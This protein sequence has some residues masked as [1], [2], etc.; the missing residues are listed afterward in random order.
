[1]FGIP[2]PY[3]LGSVAVY[4]AL[5]LLLGFTYG[6]T[7]GHSAKALAAIQRD[8]D[9]ANAKIN[10]QKPKDEAAVEAKQ[11]AVDEALDQAGTVLDKMHCAATKEAA[12]I[13]NRIR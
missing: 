1:M 4:S 11:K 5:L 12:N 10:A 13:L 8:L 9:L 3:A 6:D 7:H 2:L